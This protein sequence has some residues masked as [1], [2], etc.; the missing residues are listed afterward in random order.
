MGDFSVVVNQVSKSYGDVKA[1]ENISFSV[2][3]DE[4]YG[5]IGPDGSSAA[6]IYVV[7]KHNVKKLISSLK[8]FCFILY[9]FPS[10]LKYC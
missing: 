7:T 3:K 2:K 10:F 9:E 8:Y 4:L 5:L 6:F 1:I